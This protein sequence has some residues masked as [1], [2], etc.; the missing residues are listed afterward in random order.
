MLET[1]NLNFAQYF[2]NKD[3]KNVDTPSKWLRSPFNTKILNFGV[4]EAESS[5]S[6]VKSVLLFTL[7]DNASLISMLSV[8]FLISAINHSDSKI[9]GK[10]YLLNTCKNHQAKLIQTIDWLTTP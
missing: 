9:V 6:L 1:S 3:L 2:H 4:I 8:Y 7:L 10:C 5:S